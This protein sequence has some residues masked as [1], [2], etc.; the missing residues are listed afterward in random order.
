MRY[1]KPIYKLI[2]YPLDDKYEPQTSY[3]TTPFNLKAEI[4]YCMETVGACAMNLEIIHVGLNT[5]SLESDT[6]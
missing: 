3:S 4:S 6:D 2:V 1:L 5:L